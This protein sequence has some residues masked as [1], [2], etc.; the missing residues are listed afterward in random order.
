MSES[1]A[2]VA[3]ITA[4]L[5]VVLGPL[6]SLAVAQKQARVAVLS[7]NRQAWINSLR[8]NISEFYAAITYVHITDWKEHPAKELNDKVERVLYLE[9]KIKLM[10][11]PVEADHQKLIELLIAGRRTVSGAR[12]GKA[13][14]GEAWMKATEAL[15][16]LAHEVLKREWVRVKK[17]Q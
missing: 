12:K 4:L 8:D 11:N 10:L 17:M 7:N 3:A 5:A 1:I 2:L 15:L 6:V 16:P 14:S 9:W 13:E